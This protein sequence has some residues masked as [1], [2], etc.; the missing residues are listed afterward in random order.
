MAQTMGKPP[1]NFRPTKLTEAACDV[2]TTR[3]RPPAR[4]RPRRLGLGVDIID[5]SNSTL[6]SLAAFRRG[7]RGLSKRP[8]PPRL[9]SLRQERP[10][11]VF[12][13][14]LFR[15]KTH[16]QEQAPIGI[17]AA[18]LRSK[19]GMQINTNNASNIP[20]AISIM[21]PSTFKRSIC[22]PMC[23]SEHESLSSVNRDLIS[24]PFCRSTYLF[25]GH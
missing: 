24:I 16:D 23:L 15:E 18:M 8:T 12:A 22:A 25:S 19:N 9:I 3:R 11:T 14:T 10:A 20:P 21:T 1:R 5:R 7:D 4:G 2:W 6:T 17:S 13:R